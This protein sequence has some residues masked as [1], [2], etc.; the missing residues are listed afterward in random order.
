MP[1]LK[2]PA[3]MRLYVNGQSDVPVSGTNVAE[4]MESLLT[5]FPALRPHL[6]N[7]RGE[8]RPFV[9]LFLAKTNIRELQGLETPLDDDDQLLL[10]PAVAGG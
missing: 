3:P 7:T 1:V 5:Q 8:L 2:I 6:T 4:A 9:N 10:I